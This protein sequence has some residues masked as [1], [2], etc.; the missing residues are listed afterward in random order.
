MVLL[1]TNYFMSAISGRVMHY[2]GGIEG[3]EWVECCGVYEM[4]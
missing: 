2:W 1:N 3:Q 4:L